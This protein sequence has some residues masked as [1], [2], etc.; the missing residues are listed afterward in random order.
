[1][2][3]WECRLLRILQGTRNLPLFATRGICVDEKLVVMVITDP[4]S[5][6]WHRKVRQISNVT[7]ECFLFK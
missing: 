6:R 5:G 4:Y 3:D 7:I 2:Q 1:M